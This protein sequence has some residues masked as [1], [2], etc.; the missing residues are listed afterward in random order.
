M[1]CLWW[2]LW[3]EVDQIRLWWSL[4]KTIG[5]TEYWYRTVLNPDDAGRVLSNP[6]RMLRNAVCWRGFVIFWTFQH[7]FCHGCPNCQPEH[8]VQHLHSAATDRKQKH[9]KEG[10]IAEAEE[11]PAESDSPL[12]KPAKISISCWG[13]RRFHLTDCTAHWEHGLYPA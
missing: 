2:H 6:F 9:F 7:Q 5:P 1:V 13:E 11:W 8:A 4:L 12:C 10:E 3:R